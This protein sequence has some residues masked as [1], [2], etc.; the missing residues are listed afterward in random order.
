[1]N[2]FMRKV[3]FKRNI[4]MMNKNLLLIQDY[5]SHPLGLIVIEKWDGNNHEFIKRAENNAFGVGNVSVFCVY[6]IQISTL[7]TK[8]GLI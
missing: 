6:S 1:M 7:K 4:N 3:T 8:R 2:I 5:T